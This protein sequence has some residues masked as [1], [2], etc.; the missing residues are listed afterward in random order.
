MHRKL[1]VFFTI[2]AG[3]FNSACT[4]SDQ[5]QVAVENAWIREAPPNASAMAGYMQFVNNTEQDTDL[6]SAISQDFKVIEFHRSVEKNG[7]YRMVRYEKLIVPAQSNLELKPGDFH[8]MLISPKRALKAGDAVTIKFT[9]SN[10]ITT[11]VEIPVEKAVY[12]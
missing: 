1:I 12:E 9:F 8:L 5:P 10:Q 7:A 6:I 4:T 11:E 3:L 2:L